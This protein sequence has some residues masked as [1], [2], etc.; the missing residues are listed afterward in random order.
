MWIEAL[1]GG[2]IGEFAGQAA[3]QPVVEQVGDGEK[4]LGSSKLR[5]IG[6]YH[7]QQLV[8]GVDLHELDAGLGEDFRL[9]N[10]LEGFF[11]HAIGAGVAVVIGLAQQGTILVQ[12][13]KIHAPGIECQAFQGK[14][15]CRNRNSV[16]DLVPQAGHI[17][18]Q[19]GGVV[20]RLV[21]KTVGFGQGEF[22][23]RDCSDDGTPAFRAK[24]E[25]KIIP[26]AHD[27]L[28]I[29]HKYSVRSQLAR[30][31]RAIPG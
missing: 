23:T 4:G 10:P 11:Q 15:L 1:G 22:A 2:G 19:A 27:I 31:A 29:I 6:N 30:C 28:S 17:P 18:M 20:H 12:Q 7:R 14:L 13:G 24:V 25:G 8:Q 3:A 5:I 26:F 16:L 21:G 9:R